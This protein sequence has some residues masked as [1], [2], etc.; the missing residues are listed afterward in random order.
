MSQEN[1]REVEVSDDNKVKEELEIAIDEVKQYLASNTDLASRYA[2]PTA[3]N[4]QCP[5][6]TR[7]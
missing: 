2:N 3:D 7:V 1:S 4:V 5:S 6:I